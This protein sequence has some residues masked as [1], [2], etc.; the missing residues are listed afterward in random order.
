MVQTLKEITNYVNSVK[1]HPKPSFNSESTVNLYNRFIQEWGEHYWKFIEKYPDKNKKWYR[2][3]RSPNITMEIVEKYP[4]KP[5]DW[6]NISFN[7]NI[8]MEIIEKYPDK[9]WDW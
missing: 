6:V 9:P 3:S 1:G 8:T 4:N 7:P 2:I 5:W